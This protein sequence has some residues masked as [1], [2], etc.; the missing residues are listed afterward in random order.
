MAGHMKKA[1]WVFVLAVVALSA[2]NWWNAAWSQRS[3][4]V[5]GQH[6]PT[7]KLEDFPLLVK[8]TPGRIDY[9]SCKAN[10]LDL[11]FL[12]SSQA[13]VL[14]HEIESWKSG[15]TSV[16]WVKLP[17]LCEKGRADYIWMYYGNPSAKG[18]GNSKGVWS[19]RYAAVWHM[20]HVKVTGEVMESTKN[21][22]HGKAKG[23]MGK[24]NQVSGPVGTCLD[25][26]GRDDYI[27]VGDMPELRFERTDAFSFTAWARVRDSG[28]NS[29]ISKIKCRPTYRG[30]HFFSHHKTAA[31]HTGMVNNAHANISEQRSQIRLDDGKWRFVCATNDGSSKAIGQKLYIDGERIPM[32]LLFNKLTA[33]IKSDHPFFIANRGCL[34]AHLNGSLDEIRV[35]KEE[36]SPEWIKAQYLSQTDQLIS[37]PTPGVADGAMGSSVDQLEAPSTLRIQTNRGSGMI[38][39]HFA[40]DK[41]GAGVTLVIY[42]IIGKVIR[43]Y[44]PT[45]SS[46]SGSWTWD[47][48]NERGVRVGPGVYFV[49]LAVQAGN[50]FPCTRQ[51]QVTRKMVVF[52]E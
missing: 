1:I 27:V 4:L 9:G 47:L 34:D 49:R 33:T 31:L 17:A 18:L 41:A 45:L 30:Y 23:R 2:E 20:D 25:F 43:Q 3:K 21:G 11:V 8:L 35:V 50:E 6:K 46:V 15:D 39:F 26:D 28:L 36:L 19:D 38:N 51:Q 14:P 48:R 10:G 40:L 22:Y 29:F 5:L 32:D 37:W 42:D 13:I 12:D 52:K 24:G 44:R 16:I 7:R